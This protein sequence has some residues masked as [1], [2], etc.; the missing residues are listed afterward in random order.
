MENNKAFTLTNRGKYSFFDSHRHFLATNHKYKRNRNDFFIGKAEKDVATSRFS[1][2][3]LHDVVSEYD[4]IVF[5]FQSCKQKF[6][7]LCLTHN[8]VKRSIFWELSY[9][10]TNLLRHNL[11]IMHIEKNVFENIFN[12][13]MNVKGKTKDNIKTR[14]DITL[15]VTVKI[16]SWFLMGHKLQNP[17]QASCWRNMHNN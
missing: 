5:G 4:D 14:M 13:V 16:C 9:W 12:T 6:H 1:S 10:K 3:E 2:E 11:D 15:F 17:D 8:W 7:G